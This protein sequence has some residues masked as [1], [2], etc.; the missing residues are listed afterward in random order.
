VQ[1][2]GR[3]T[4]GTFSKGNSGKPKG[5]RNLKTIALESLLE[6]QAE[7]LTQ[8]AINMA[9][10]GDTVALRLCMDRIAPPAKD[11]PVSFDLPLMKSAQSAC[12]AAGSVLSAVGEGGLT[13]LEAAR[14]MGLVDSYRRMLEWTDLED[15]L[16]ALENDFARA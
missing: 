1:N 4:D 3:N 8:K 13:P 12:E 6:G 2:Y 14:I 7:A 5:A 9:L 15:R 10:E 11:K 16:V